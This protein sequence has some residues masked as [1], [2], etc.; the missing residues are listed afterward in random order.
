MRFLELKNFVTTVIGIKLIR[1]EI[2]HAN[3]LPTT[4]IYWF[5]QKK[6]DMDPAKLPRNE[7]SDSIYQKPDND[8]IGPWIPW[9][10][11]QIFQIKGAIHVNRADRS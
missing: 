2:L 8:P 7:K 11:T 5:I 4:I 1:H 10:L 6:P 9:I 3:S